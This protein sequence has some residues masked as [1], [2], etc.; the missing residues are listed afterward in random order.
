MNCISHDK[1]YT[2]KKLYEKDSN[3]KILTKKPTFKMFRYHE[4]NHM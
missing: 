4:K 2:T 1:R 3:S